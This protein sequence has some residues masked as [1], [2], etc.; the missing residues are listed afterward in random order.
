MVFHSVF[1]NSYLWLPIVGFVIGLFGSVIGGGGG[2]FFL[3]VLILGFNVPAQVAVSTS[4][5]ATLPICIGGAWEHYRKRNI[6]L[7]TGFVF[8]I[9]GIFGALLGARFTGVLNT[10]QLKIAFGIYSILLAL[11]MLFN[12]WRKNRADARGIK[13]KKDST[14]RKNTKRSFYGF[15]AGIITGTF[16]TSGTAPVL[17]GLFSVK[18]PVKMIAGTSLLIVFVNTV[19]ALGAHFM[20]GRIDFTLV[21][22]L[23]LGSIVGSVTGPRLIPGARVERAEKPVRLWFALIMIA[24]GLL[25]ILTR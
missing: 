24:F 20:I 8:A 10:N 22:F 11:V 15:L 7:P 2:F 14:T 16:G 25:M 17:A 19:S 21:Y 12:N 1:E 4:L 13:I 18:L 3:P 23:T 6:D 5:A 9:A